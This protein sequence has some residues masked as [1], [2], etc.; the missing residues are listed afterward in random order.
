M[1]RRGAP[2]LKIAVLFIS[3]FV[4]AMNSAEAQKTPTGTITLRLENAKMA[5]VV[6]P[7]DIHTKTIK[8]I[9]CHHK[10]K[11]PTR[12]EKCG[13]CHLIKKVK[14]KAP[15]IRD[16][17]HT[18]CQSCH[19]DLRSKGVSAPTGCNECHKK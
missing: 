10:D 6:F 1:R 3:I 2:F 18:K 14:E 16:A 13:I 8:C 19:K 12:P 5:P 17:F 7:H 9:D 15:S 11:D 4:F